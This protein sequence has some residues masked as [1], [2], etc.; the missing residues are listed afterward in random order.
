MIADVVIV[1]QGGVRGV[2]ELVKKSFQE[3]SNSH[4]DNKYPVPSK[5]SYQVAVYDFPNSNCG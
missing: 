5:N 2:M 1:T 3:G 4:N